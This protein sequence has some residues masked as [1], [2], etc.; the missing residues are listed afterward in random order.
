MQIRVFQIGGGSRRGNSL[1]VGLFAVGAGIL[2]LSFGLILLA[3]LATVGVVAGAGALLL[4]ALRG[5]RGMPE[6]QLR[7]GWR[8]TLDPRL[9][10]RMAD[11]DD[12]DVAGRL[13]AGGGQRLDPA[14]RIEPPGD[15]HSTER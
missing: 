7:D 11:A 10:V 12:S 5:P 15:A 6:P 8:A 13:A 3:A 1:V 2:F 4:R 14:N 9:E